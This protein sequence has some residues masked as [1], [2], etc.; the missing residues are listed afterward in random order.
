MQK[1]DTSV[2]DW[3]NCIWL[4]D[5]PSNAKFIACY[6][7]KFMNSQKDIAYPSYARMIKETGLSRGCLAK[8][9]ALLESE[10]WI[11]R[12]KTIGSN[13]TYIA[14]LP[15]ILSDGL[16]SSLNILVHEMNYPSSPDGQ[17]LVHEV[18]TN[19]QCNNQ[20]NKQVKDIDR[21]AYNTLLEN[22]F[23]HVWKVFKDCKSRINKT[24]TS[25]KAKTFDKNWKKH[26]N[27]SY[28]KNNSEQE[29]KSEVNKIADFIK[30]A[31]AITGFNRFENM[32]LAKLL[33]EK[34]WND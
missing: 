11:V 30:Q 34:Q 14:V 3:L 31:H 7:R 8:Y 6:L 15:Q 10:G 4:T 12:D 9:L 5:L 17:V 13:T 20:Y 16:A 28:F 2:V 24:D 18:D 29:Y 27:T 1:A 21:Q 19:K 26:F 22:G 25:P 33:S 23:N 32:Q